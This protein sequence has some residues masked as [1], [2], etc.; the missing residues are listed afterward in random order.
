MPESA[1]NRVNHMAKQQKSL[2]GLKCG[3][4]QNLI[5]HRIST[6]V[7]DDMDDISSINLNHEIVI[8]DPKSESVE[9]TE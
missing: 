7:I 2:K 4:R 3:D 1:I 8:E 9:H 5:D 6:G